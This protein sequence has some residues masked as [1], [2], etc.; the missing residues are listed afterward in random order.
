VATNINLN[1]CSDT[2]RW[3]GNASNV[4][5]DASNW[6]CGKLPDVNSIV[7]IPA[8]LPRYPIVFSFAEIKKLLLQNGATITVKSGV[9]FKLNGQ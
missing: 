5:G 2:L 8:G 9:Q 4:W 6:D 1:I 3:N 7:Y